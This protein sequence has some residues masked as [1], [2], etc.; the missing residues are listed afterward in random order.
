LR[1]LPNA[2]DADPFCHAGAGFY[3]RV[4]INGGSS[5]RLPLL[6]GLIFGGC[7][8]TCSVLIGPPIRA[9]M[10]AFH[11]LVTRSNE[12]FRKRRNKDFLSMFPL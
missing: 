12:D 9:L 3:L 2:G 4:G 8:I 7:A 6:S 5:G 11:A 1:A 10:R